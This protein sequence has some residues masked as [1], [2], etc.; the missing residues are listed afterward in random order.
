MRSGPRDLP[1]TAALSG[2]AGHGQPPPCRVCSTAPGRDWR[3][4]AISCSLSRAR[5][6][7]L[8]VNGVPEAIRT[9]TTGWHGGSAFHIGRAIGGNHTAG[10]IDRIRIWAGARSDAEISALSQE[11]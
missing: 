6:L 9:N 5:Q 3:P 8:Y 1:A 2:R 4:M 11:S 7:K 10:T